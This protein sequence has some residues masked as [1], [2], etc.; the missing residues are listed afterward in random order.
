M[1]AVAAKVSA[2]VAP[3]AAPLRRAS[4]G[5]KPH[6][7]PLRA[8]ARTSTVASAGK[9]ED[10]MEQLLAMLGGNKPG[11]VTEKDA[12]PGRQEEMRVSDKHFVLGNSI[13][14]FPDNLETCVFATGC[15]WGTEKMFWRVPGVFS[16][17]V[18][19][20]GGFTQNPT[21]EGPDRRV[22]RGP[23]RH[24]LDLPRPHAGQ[25]PGQRLRHAIPLWD[26][27]LHVCAVRDGQGERGGVLEG[28]RGG[29]TRAERHHDG[30]QR[31]GG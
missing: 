16:T 23:T 2:V 9:D 31:P 30:N 24:A 20:V 4:P 8:P 15:F 7:S 22:L 5:S 25:P 14:T 17:S 12:L 1:F 28:A 13:K 19:Y 26:L 3:R 27:L 11:M 18:G 10:L 6:R 29:G 21:Y